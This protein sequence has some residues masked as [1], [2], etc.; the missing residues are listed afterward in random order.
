[1]QDQI[2][3]LVRGIIDDLAQPSPSVP[4]VAIFFQAIGADG[5]SR[6]AAKRLIPLSWA[7]D[8]T[9][10]PDVCSNALHQL[11]THPDF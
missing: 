2:D 3:Q 10:P 4:E 11:H 1:M 6:A 7:S 9:L 5:P 8:V